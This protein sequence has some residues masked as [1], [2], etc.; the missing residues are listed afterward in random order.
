MFVFRRARW[1]NLKSGT[2][3]SLKCKTAAAKWIDG[4]L[5]VKKWH[6]FYWEDSF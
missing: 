4:S 5:K 3:F 2:I 6:D 1:F